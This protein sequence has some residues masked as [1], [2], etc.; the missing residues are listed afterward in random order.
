MTLAVALLAGDAGLAGV[1]WVAVTGGVLRH[2]RRRLIVRIIGVVRVQSIPRYFEVR[3]AMDLRVGVDVRIEVRLAVVV[4]VPLGPLLIGDGGVERLLEAAHAERELGGLAAGQDGVRGVVHDEARHAG[5]V[6]H[7]AQAGH[8]THRQVLPL[9]EQRVEGDLAVLVGV[10]VTGQILCEGQ[11]LL[12]GVQSAA[13]LYQHVVGSLR[14][15]R[16]R[17]QH[18]R[19]RNILAVCLKQRSLRVLQ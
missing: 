17:P 5:G 2:R 7:A 1:A 3:T 13:V 10:P 8:G 16:K 14:N 19:H 4:V 9:H 6:A 15:V 18:D 11:R 12:H